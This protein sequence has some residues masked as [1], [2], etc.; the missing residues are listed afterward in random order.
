MEPHGGKL[1]E[2]IA[3]KEK[4]EKIV[5]EK[6][7]TKIELDANHLKEVENICS[8]AFSPLEGFMNHNEAMSV[9]EKMRL[10]N[11]T[12]WTIPILLP[13]SEKNN[14][15][16]GDTV[17]LSHNGSIV[18][19]MDV[20]ERFT[21][22]KNFMAEKIYKT[23][24]ENHPGVKETME[25]EGHFI[26]GK[27]ELIQTQSHEHQKYDLMPKETRILFKEKGWRTVVGF[28][29]RNVPHLGHE[30]VQKTALTFTDGLFI[31]PVIGK[32]KSGDFKDEV[33]LKS[34]EKLI[35]HYYLRDRA[36]MSILKTRMRYA[37]PREAIF[38]AII[39]KNFGCTHFIV[40]RDHAGVGK[41][42]GPYDAQDIFEEFSDLGITPLF[43]RSFYYCK[44]CESIVNDKICPHPPEYHKNFSGTK[45]RD[46][47]IKKQD[48]EGMMRKEVLE[49][50]L[51]YDNPFVE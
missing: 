17:A 45:M 49:T 4:S 22:D 40:G 10:P 26:G 21:L 9:L 19:I 39:R 24:D 38:H 8:G 5:Q 11:D 29:T 48:P 18:A 1:I 46:K 47:I 25:L 15:Q 20:N 2:R 33:I 14:T 13:I 27:V 6:G 28:Q 42:Y 16:P 51:E 32:K 43:F 35:E 12:A 7:L 30:Y 44:K 3:S 50:I 23:K 34:Y 36:V 41:F 31:N 37:G